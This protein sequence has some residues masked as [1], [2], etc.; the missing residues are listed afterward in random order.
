[1]E[2]VEEDNAEDDSVAAIGADVGTLSVGISSYPTLVPGERLMIE[3]PDDV[4]DNAQGV[5]EKRPL[6]VQEEL[7]RAAS[8]AGLGTD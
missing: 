5:V 1:V 7:Q 3:V 8:V 2:E 6:T 4:N